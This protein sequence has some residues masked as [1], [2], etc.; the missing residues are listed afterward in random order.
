MTNLP[1][2]VSL[3]INEP[4]ASSHRTSFA[5]ASVTLN[6]VGTAVYLYGQSASYSTTL[7][8]SQSSSSSTETGLLYSQAGLSYGSHTL[9]LQTGQGQTS[10]SNAIITVGLG[11][12]GSALI[13]RA[14]RTIC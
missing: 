8:G 7:D 2:L 10:I 3:L 13:M 14:L 12:V 11:A 9:V 1:P 4:K 6:W 5:G